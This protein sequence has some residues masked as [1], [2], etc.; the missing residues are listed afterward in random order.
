MELRRGQGGGRWLIPRGGEREGNPSVEKYAG[1]CLPECESVLHP[2][3][4]VAALTGWACLGALGP[5]E[6]GGSL[7]PSPPLA[8]AQENVPLH[9]SSAPARVFVSR[10]SC[11]HRAWRSA[12]NG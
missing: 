4:S 7:G 3:F 1:P 6:G 12:R 5:R 10:G 8:P 9:R 11:C 2:E